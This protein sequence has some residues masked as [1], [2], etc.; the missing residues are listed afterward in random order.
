MV[1]VI[2]I[3]EDSWAMRNLYPLA[4]RTEVEKDIAAAAEAGEKNRAPSGFG[5]TDIYISQPPSQNYA[6]HGLALETVASALEQI[7]PRVRR[8]NAT[9]YSAMNS[10]VRD[11]YGSYEEDAW[12]F[13]LGE[14][15]Y[16]K[17][18]PKDGM[19]GNIWFDLNTVDSDTEYLLRRGL[20]AID[21]LIPSVIAD[22]YLDFSGPVSDPLALDNYFAMFV[23]T[24]RY[25]EQAMLDYRAQ[26]EKAEKSP[27]LVGKL[28]SFLR[29]RR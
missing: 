7:M 10:D 26:Y 1:D 3:H 16:I 20:E 17:I 9:V 15:C 21:R 14:H 24:R 18:D 5:Y 23:E 25:A 11:P 8:F 13:G 19:A 28:L 29:I 12:C 27:G 22:Y 2:H 4:V 6:D